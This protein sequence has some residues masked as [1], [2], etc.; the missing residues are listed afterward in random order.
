MNSVLLNTETDAKTFAPSL[1]REQFTLKLRVG[2]SLAKNT[3]FLYT[4]TNSL[5]DNKS[6]SNI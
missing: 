5:A 1:N 4:V 6:V 2:G 3:K